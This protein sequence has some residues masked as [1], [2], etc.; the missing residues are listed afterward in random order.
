MSSANLPTHSHPDRTPLDQ[1]ARAALDRA[2]TLV[3]EESFFAMVDPVPEDLAAPD[4][5]LLNVRVTFE[6]GFA[7]TL[8]CTMPRA[9]AHELTA[10]FS[11]ASMDE[12][13]VADPAI[14]D[15][16]GEFANMICGRWL[17]DVAPQDLFSL[18]HPAITPVVAP[19]DRAPHGLLNGQPI[20][21]EL[22]VER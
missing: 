19:A 14:D 4:G 11:G 17:T 18:T 12:I 10:A 1:D 6:G 7:G 3:A 22:T 9:L 2:L 13:A 8:S 15:L 21:I 5:H 20:W 16:V